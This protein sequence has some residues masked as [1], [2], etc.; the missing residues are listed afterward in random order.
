MRYTLSPTYSH[1]VKPDDLAEAEAINMGV[2][3]LAA[4]R[5]ELARRWVRLTGRLRQR[6]FR[7]SRK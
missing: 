6:A 5:K 2:A 7:E 4:Q 1:V 3:D